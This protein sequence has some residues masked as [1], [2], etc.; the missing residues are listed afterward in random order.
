MTGVKS[1]L[2][3]YKVNI[4]VKKPCQVFLS[5]ILDQQI[6]LY[7]IKMIH[8]NNSGTFSLCVNGKSINLK[9][10]KVILHF[11]R[12]PT[13]QH[14]LSEPS[15]D[16]KILYSPSSPEY[17]KTKPDQNDNNINKRAN[18]SSHNGNM[19]SNNNEAQTNG[20]YQPNKIIKPNPPTY[21]KVQ[22]NYNIW[23]PRVSSLCVDET[24]YINETNLPIQISDV[25]CMPFN[26][27]NSPN[28][29][30]STNVNNR[31]VLGS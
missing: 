15:C 25:H 29:M 1:D 19:N 11:K 22:Q 28:T 5:L 17:L 20:N 21:N 12:I 4:L 10:H 9:A 30:D 13:T 3:S 16:D 2:F 14:H 26:S 8:S 27:D 7:N 6:I 24:N 18:F 23:L 31:E